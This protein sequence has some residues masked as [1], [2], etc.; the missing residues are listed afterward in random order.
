M[1]NRCT[2]KEGQRRCFRNGIGNPVLC[3]AH[4]AEKEADEMNRPR[5]NYNSPLD[6]ILDAI[7]PNGVFDEVVAV[8][9]DAVKDA[10]RTMAQQAASRFKDWI[11]TKAKEN[12]QVAA[13]AAQTAMHNKRLFDELRKARRAAAENAARAAQAE[14]RREDPRD[15]LGFSPDVKI[16]PQIIK[17]RQREL[18]RAF[19]PDKGGS[20]K[21]MQRVNDA[22]KE[23]L[24]SL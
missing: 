11:S 1:D 8:A 23:L 24:A 22:A 7:D 12:P 5:D 18:A 16:T 9:D 2:Y 17:E 20:V 14:S 3:K 4:R 15:V 6:N 21:A 13:T 19:H 10:A